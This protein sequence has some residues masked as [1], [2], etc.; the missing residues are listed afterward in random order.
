VARVVGEEVSRVSRAQEVPWEARWEPRTSHKRV[1][2]FALLPL[3][4]ALLPDCGTPG[5]AGGHLC[6][7][8]ALIDH[9]LQVLL[10]NEV[11]QPLRIL[12]TLGIVVL[13]WLVRNL[14][15][16]STKVNWRPWRRPVGP[17]LQ[18]E[19]PVLLLGALLH[20]QDLFE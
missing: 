17:R 1:H 15:V 7:V 12:A 18:L 3:C 5:T 6:L 20:L 9:L 4:L 8:P 10:P 13:L 11:N 2:S 19:G 14:I 16:G